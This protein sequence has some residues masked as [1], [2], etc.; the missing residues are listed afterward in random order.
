M[1]PL[2]CPYCEK[3]VGRCQRPSGVSFEEAIL[4]QSL[5]YLYWPCLHKFMFLTHSNHRQS[6]GEVRNQ[7][8][9]KAGIPNLKS[10]FH[11]GTGKEPFPQS[12]P[13]DVSP[14]KKTNGLHERKKHHHY[15]HFEA[16]LGFQQP[17]GSL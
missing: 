7:L 4:F 12:S 3:L 17:E 8:R 1:S 13:G 9:M 14:Q 2:S 15:Q 16:E 5:R 6:S 11:F 10:E